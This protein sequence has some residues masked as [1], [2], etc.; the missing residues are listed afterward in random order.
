MTA[1]L[2]R[3]TVSRVSNFLFARTRRNNIIMMFG[4]KLYA[5][6]NQSLN[7]RVGKYLAQ[8]ARHRFY[9][10]SRSH[11]QEKLTPLASQRMRVRIGR[12]RLG[13]PT[14]RCAVYFCNDCHRYRLHLKKEIDAS[15][16][17]ICFKT[18]ELSCSVGRALLLTQSSSTQHTRLPARFWNSLRLRGSD[19][20]SSPCFDQEL[21][22]WGCDTKFAD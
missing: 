14:I 9:T 21:F 6:G 20:D 22:P 17:N 13:A 10:I 15:A 2:T 19:T 5:T 1:I 4:G 8:V 16:A 3:P 7:L 12:A 18:T 11:D